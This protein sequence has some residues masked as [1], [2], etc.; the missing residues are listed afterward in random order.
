MSSS[1]K[2]WT[3][4]GIRTA[5]LQ[6]FEERG[7]RIVPS[8]GSFPLDDPTLLFTNAGM[9][10]FKDMFLG[11]GTRDYTRAVDTQKCIRVSGKHNDLEEV[12]VDG[13]HHTF[14]EMLGNWSFGDY[15]KEEAI[16]WAWTLLTEVFGLPKER[17]W[18]TVYGGDKADGLGPDEEAERIW[19]EK[20]DI[21]PS[22]V[23]RLGKSE[24]FWEMG[25]TGPCGP[26][27]E[28]HIDRGGPETNP[29]DG[30]S[31]EFGIPADNERYMELW[32][33]VFMQFLRLDDGS[34]KELPNKHVDTGLGLER[35]V[36]TMQGVDSNYH[37]DLFL[38]IIDAIAVETGRTYERGESSTDV[39]FRVCADHMR[40]LTAALSDG[41]SPSNTGRGYVMRRLIRRAARF[42]TQELGMNQPW[43]YKLVPVVAEV[44][45]ES[46]PEMRERLD[47][48]QLI[49]K[50]EETSFGRTLNRG[51]TLFDQ[52]A[53]Q[54]EERGATELPGDEAFELY[55]TSGFPQD[56]VE[57]M[58]R[59]RGMTVDLAGWDTAE[60]KHKN[61]SKSEG[62]FKQL[63]SAE[64]LE[65][66]DGET[67]STYHDGG[68]ASLELS[69]CKVLFAAE[70]EPGQL[71]LV[72]DT[73]PFY[74]ESGGQAGDTGTISSK[75]GE[76]VMQVT[77]TKKVAGV[78]VH[79]GTVA[80]GAAPVAGTLVT[81]RVAGA[82]RDLT[83]KNH[84]ATHLLNQAL[85]EV[86]GDHVAQQGSEVD[87]ERLRFDFSNPKGLTPEQ[88]DRVEA[89]VNQQIALNNAVEVTEENLDDARA[90]GV[91]AAFGEKYG[92]R[93][94]VVDMGAWSTELCGGTHV[95]RT[96]D[97]GSFTISQERAIS[98]GV[99]RI[100]GLTGPAAI[101]EFQEQRRT[102]RGAASI[103]KTS[104]G[105]L[106]GRLELL[107]K[108]LKEAKKKQKASKG[109]DA[110]AT[111]EALKGAA[112]LKG[113]VTWVIQDLPESDAQAVGEIAEAGK[114]L[115]ADLVLVLFGRDG[116]K[117]PFVVVS[118]GAALEN[119]HKAGDLAKLIAGHLGGGGGGRPGQAQGRGLKADGVPGAMEQLSGL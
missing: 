71:S 92:E 5:Y 25:A 34:L 50:D 27:T 99:R 40:A 6:F 33:L 82:R 61:A 105:E 35:I 26:C 7:H 53:G 42:G 90:R 24:N 2:S 80:K 112:Q 46:F 107:Q 41:V 79:L 21:L 83:A 65:A 19:K 97:I 102:L 36:A 56:L 110:V 57:Q 39:A 74:A 44:L 106:Q 98:A 10:Q 104:P 30:A 43:L 81:A 62:S 114:A 58:A 9:N 119:G 86:L 55:A 108:Q 15:F 32:N 113:D 76:H 70:R 84:S 85:R 69:G 89:I 72:L 49:I 77:G 18:V 117:V 87:S 115:S 45:G 95:Q 4:S 109:T 38:P 1:Q 116:G 73:S 101:A 14:F 52:L 100:E 103:L 17:L 88:I 31:L 118:Q 68:E 54:V 16:E 8:S 22:H 11:T 64:E 59:E 28:I 23:L 13:H 75:D 29:E 63:L 51:I 78:V 47:H 48:V 67:R 66:I 60:G 94:R 37:T 3:A 91:V 12:G 93:V 20:T 96:G 111:V